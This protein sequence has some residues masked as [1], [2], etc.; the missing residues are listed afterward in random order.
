MQLLQVIKY[1]MCSY[2]QIFQS[3]MQLLHFFVSIK[4][5]F[6]P[7]NVAMLSELMKYNS[8]HKGHIISNIA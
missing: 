6:K 4:M 3:V 1:K 2:L 7:D 8:A 5:K